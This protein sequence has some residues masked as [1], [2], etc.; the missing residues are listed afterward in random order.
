MG[1]QL[2]PR[3]GVFIDISEEMAKYETLLSDREVADFEAF[4]LIYR[5]LCAVL[6]NYVPTSGHPGGSISSGRIVASV[7]FG[8]MD[9]DLGDPDRLEADL[10]S[11]AAGH[12]AM[13]LYAMWAMRTEVARLAAPELVPGEVKKQL[14][15]EDL[16]GFRRNPVTSTR[17]F[18][19]HQSK[20]LDGHPTPQTPFV[21]LSTGASGVG[22]ASS[23]GLAF[24]A[25]D[26]FGEM[27]PRV[28]IIEGEGGLT[29]GR[30]SESL[31]A[32]G[33]ASLDNAL[34]HLDWN[35]ASIDSN[36]VCREG[37]VPGDYVQWNPIELF[38]LH[39][40][41][42]ITVPDGTDHRQIAAAMKRATE[43]DT[44]QP[45]AIVYTTTKGWQYGIEG[46]AS[47]GAGHKLCSGGYYD[48]LSQLLGESADVLPSCQEGNRRCEG[49]DGPAVMEECFW[50]A[51]TVVRSE[52]AKRESMLETMAGRLRD[53]KS[54]LDAASRVPREGAPHLD[55]V[56][57][58][59]SRALDSQPDHLGLT[60]GSVT[61]LRGELGKV[62]RYYN[63]ESGGALLVSAA[64]LLGSTSIS[65]A[66]ADFSEGFYN[67]GSNPGS[68][69]LMCGGICEDAM[70]GIMSGLSTYGHHIGAGS[71]YGAFI[72]PL[73]HIPARLHAIGSQARREAFG[74][75][76]QT[77]FLV[78]AH[79]G[80]KTGEDGP[81]H[82]DPQALQILQENFPRG[83]LITLTPWDPQE[84]WPLV[85][86]ALAA[87]PAVVAPFVTRPGEVVPD[88]EKLRLAPAAEAAKGVYRLRASQDGS[89]GTLV[90]QGSEVGI[91]FTEEVLPRLDE[92]GFDL[93]IYYVASTELFDL[94]PEDEQERV[95][96]LAHRNEAMGITGF[97]QPT[98]YRWVLSD[99][100][101]SMTMHPFQKGHYLG[102]G[103]ARMVMAEAGMDGESQYEAVRSY[104]EN[105]S[106]A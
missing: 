54:R 72:A 39:D 80:I 44:G 35:Q 52:M 69:I 97:T 60:P 6:F 95:F 12:K 40:W 27:S 73:G 49:P 74:G 28:H 87:R 13:G 36:R 33:T 20:A 101:R 10:I 53:A 86:A 18:V 66:A 8:G 68:R 106:K 38:Y 14:R 93:D 37:D 82:A 56:F 83:T 51:L 104:V 7:L 84:V 30:V 47:H 55:S 61:T 96:P 32:S 58:I 62:L 78:C 43:I 91:A 9:Y 79:A 24:G 22:V 65:D 26:Y 57:E 2:G 64:D 5:A 92:D 71:S 34:V 29:P 76:Y 63:K 105:R 67:A 77:M 50:E 16:L 48:A 88:R 11:Y 81:T 42:V 3:R 94:L 90:L 41:N 45:T 15:F 100:G 1:F 89:D 17:L 4:D 31:A 46:R 98:I 70:M 25:K 21:K 59:A 75:D 103:V 85:G 99:F 23:L 19:E 102:S